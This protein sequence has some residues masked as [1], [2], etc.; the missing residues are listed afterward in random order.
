[1]RRIDAVNDTSTKQ[2][3]LPSSLRCYLVVRRLD[4]NPHIPIGETRH[5]GWYLASIGSA[6]YSDIL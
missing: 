4:N 2:T 3:H 5:Y 1:M 6:S